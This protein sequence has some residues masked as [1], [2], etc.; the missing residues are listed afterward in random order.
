MYCTK[1]NLEFEENKKSCPRCGAAIQENKKTTNRVQ[2]SKELICSIIWSAFIFTLTVIISFS[3][4]TKIDST[5]GGLNHNY[6][7]AV[8]NN[9]KPII[10][11]FSGILILSSTIATI[12]FSKM[13]L[14]EKAVSFLVAFCSLASSIYMVNFC[15]DI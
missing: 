15:L 4:H 6:V 3:L 9:S 2:I 10:I 11:G 8:P 5:P 14:K 12:L 13:N 1:C 7:M